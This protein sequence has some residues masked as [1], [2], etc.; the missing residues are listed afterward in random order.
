M[1]IGPSQ[2]AT[3]PISFPCFVIGDELIVIDW[4]VRLVQGI[5]SRGAPIV[6]Q[7]RC[8]RN[9]SS[10]EED[11]E[12]VAFWYRRDK[13][14]SGGGEEIGKG[15]DGARRGIGIFG[16]DN[17]GWKGTRVGDSHKRFLHALDGRCIGA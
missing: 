8:Y 10:G 2:I 14:R 5:R 15:G 1:Q 7:T 16:Y 12:T 13:R 17:G 4:T 9:S 6:S 11:R 3:S